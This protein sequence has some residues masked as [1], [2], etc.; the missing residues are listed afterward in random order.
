MA[1][2]KRNAKRMATVDFAAWSESFVLNKEVKVKDKVLGALY[3]VGSSQKAQK[4]IK[5]FA[6][7]WQKEALLKAARDVTTFISQDG[8]VWIVTGKTPES[9]GHYG[10]VDESAYAWARDQVGGL[11][12]QFKSH[13]LG[14]LR[15]EFDGLSSEQELGALVGLDMAAYNFRQIYQ[16]QKV[17]LPSVSLHNLSKKE[18]LSEARARA[19]AVNLARHLVNLPPNDLNPGSYAEL[20][21][22]GLK[23]PKSVKVTVW[24]QAKLEQEGMGLHLSVGRGSPNGPC[25]VHLQYRPAK[26][27]KLKPIAFVGKGITFDTGGL[28]IKPSSGMRLM[29][30]DMGGSAAVMGLVYYAAASQYPGPLDFYLALA[31]NSVDGQSF[32]PS[33]VVTARNGLKVEIDNTDAEGRLVLADVLDVA[34]S[35]KGAAEPEM[36]IDLA[37]LT[38]AIKVGL[39]S[40]IAGLFCND[41][42]LANQIAFAG[43]RAGDL[44]WR[45]PL[46]S[47][48][49]EGLNSPFA[50]FKNCG[51]G[52]GGAITA[53]LFLQKFI[54]GKKW[55]H[56]DIYAWADRSQGALQASG[57]SGQGV[58]ALIEF[59]NS[60]I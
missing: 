58:Q 53:A 49:F 46:Y 22:K 54:N 47:K 38:G 24:N 35:S 56:L 51:P 44:S 33:D 31:E 2:K 10:L 8:P 1:P 52:F 16:G 3:F 30:K 40:D 36:V 37:T 13:Q 12:A 32:R 26:K 6:L 14:A 15:I 4:I 60:R 19:M 39:G 27:S 28:D 48:Y 20:A 41:D 55:A 34:S 5:D 59:L 18:I 43:S 17:E 50:D 42:E 23:L 25:M 57:G 29:K 45:M 9:E 7:Q 11:F 21:Q